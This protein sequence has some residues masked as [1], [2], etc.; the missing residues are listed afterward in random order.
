MYIVL[1]SAPAL[2]QEFGTWFSIYVGENTFYEDRGL[3]LYTTYQYRLTVYNSFGHTTSAA[4]EEVATFGGTPTRAAE[5]TVTA[6]NHTSVFVSW[7]TPCK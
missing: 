2:A 3:T 1:S 7:I 5:V 4:S 6:V